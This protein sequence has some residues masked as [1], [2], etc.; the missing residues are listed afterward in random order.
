MYERA[1]VER[2]GNPGVRMEPE[3]EL[4]RG[5]GAPPDIGNEIAEMIG[6]RALRR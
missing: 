2:H 3:E 4:D 5:V 1:R 6:F